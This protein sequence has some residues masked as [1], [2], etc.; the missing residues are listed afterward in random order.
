[1]KRIALLIIALP[2]V[3]AACKKDDKKSNLELLTNSGTWKIS[4]IYIEKGGVVALDYYSSMKSCEKDNSYAFN[5]DYSITSYEG[6][7]KCDLSVK[8][9][10]TDGAWTL[11]NN[12]SVF[13]IK[14]SKI[15]PISGDQSMNILSLDNS[16]L[17]LTKDTTIDY[18]GIGIITGTIH[19]TFNKK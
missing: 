9:T 7:T 16:T 3:F 5:K 18:P 10:T 17:K 15:L 11:S 19:A 12:E 4:E 8:D 2:F 14:N 6:A 13:V 1:M